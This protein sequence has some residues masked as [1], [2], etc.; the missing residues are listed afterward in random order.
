MRKN[1]F[2]IG[3]CTIALLTNISCSKDSDT[4][5]LINSGNTVSTK[6]VIREILEVEM[7]TAGTLAEK[8][9]DQSETVQKLVISGPINAAD[10]ETFRNL[11]A[12]LAIDLKDATLT[13]DET[14]Y[15]FSGQSY[16][17][18]DNI[19]SPYMFSGTQLSEIVLPDNITEIEEK[20]FWRLYGTNENPF[21]SIVIPEGVTILREEAFNECN[22]LI[23]V[24]LP[25]TLT[26]IESSVFRS[27]NELTR[28]NL[29]G[30]THLGEFAFLD[31]SSLQTIKLPETL[32][33]IG[34][35]CFWRSGLTSIEI[36]ASVTTLGTDIF[37]ETPLHSAV[38]PENLTSIPNLMFYECRS[39]SSVNIPANVESIGENAF[40]NC[41]SLNEITFPETLT[42]IGNS[43]FYG[44]GIKNLVIPNSV[45]SIAPSAFEGCTSLES[46]TL[47][48]KLSTIPVACFRNCS[49]LK[50]VTL[51]ESV[52]RIEENGFDICTSLSE[53][54]LPS[55]LEYIGN[56][57]FNACTA[58]QYITLPESLTEIGGNAF[59][60]SGLL[61]IELP[62][63][64]EIIGAGAFNHTLIKTI[65]IPPSVKT[66]WPNV[67]SGC[68]QLTSIFWDA[69][70]NTSNALFSGDP[71]NCLIYISD[72]NVAVGNSRE[73]PNIII[74]G[75]ADEIILYD[76]STSDFNVPKEF[77]TLKISY[78]KNFSYPTY[79]G[80]AAGWYSIY[81]PFTPT[82]ITHEDGRV[83][84]PFNAEVEG[85][86]PFWLR[87]LTTN[88]FE[89]MTEIEAN[90]PYII[91]MP[92]NEVY[93]DEYNISGR[94]TF[95]AED[96]YGI[97]IPATGDM[98]VDNGPKFAFHGTFVNIPAS[99]TIYALKDNTHGGY[100]AG[101]AFVRNERITRPFE[102]YVT[103]LSIASNAPAFFNIGGSTP[104]TRSAKPLGPVPSIDDM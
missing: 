15:T 98:T 32:V 92:N 74:N 94:V 60:N 87:R 6:V 93:N 37:R 62:S 28:I 20:A 1:I 22:N 13:S 29:G 100:Y 9:G 33:S 39:L 19:I 12:L 68:S 58:L 66:F 45:E 75:V 73:T 24:T 90:V 31:C 88:G 53:V 50:A 27:C 65:T 52:T 11:P 46:V 21:E 18:L 55:Q 56:G 5:A 67:F 101:S 85:A 26:E 30:V 8:I 4:E 61:E 99:S 44:C 34:N 38:L 48:N 57:V 14:T 2:T 104:R 49:A 3:L 78:S 17:L 79:P 102:G 83:L 40:R 7:E 91:A 10:V 16:Q 86:K 95:S 54:Q 41:K 51:P 36:P 77:R 82:S 81:L 71:I 70:I 43:A 63:N 64:I 69:H 35:D 96:P 25:S 23:E 59:A 42:S 103:N 80:Q 76:A 72:P 84:A 47:S 97:T 89:N